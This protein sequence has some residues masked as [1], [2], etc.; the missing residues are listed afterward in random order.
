MAL[1]VSDHG[2]RPRGN[3]PDVQI[4]TD[5]SAC[6]R[7]GNGGWAAVIRFNGRMLELADHHQSSDSNHMELLAAVAALRSIPMPAH[8]TL[9][10]DSAYLAETVTSRRL[11]AWTEL[12]A[13][14]SS[15]RPVANIELWRELLLLCA[16]HHVNVV[17]VRGHSGVAG[18]EL[19][20]RI[21]GAA[22]RRRASH[23]R[24]VG[25]IPHESDR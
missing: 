18:N 24:V 6:Q 14:S 25:R 21:A 12:D 13:R 19:A 15:G 9:H 10:T 23:V 16:R 5:G 20:D 4:W 2:E 22:R 17:K 3:L 7:S 11:H 1:T 8:V